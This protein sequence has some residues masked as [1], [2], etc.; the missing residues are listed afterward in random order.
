MALTRTFGPHSMASDIVSESRPAFAAAYAAIVGAGRVAE[1]DEMLTIAA[2]AVLLLHHGVGRLRDQERAEQVEPHDLVVEARRRG[3]RVGARRPAGVVDQYV[4]ATRVSDHPRHQHLD[5]VGVPDVADVVVL[6]IDLGARAGEHPCAGGAERLGDAEPDPACAAGDQH[7]TAGQVQ[8]ERHAATLPS[9]CLVRRERAD[10]LRSAA[11]RDPR[12]ITMEHPP[13]N[14][15]TV[16]GWFDVAAA[17]DEASADH[18]HE[19]RGPP[20]GGQ[21]LQRRRR[22]QGDA[23]HQRVRRPAGRQ[24][25]LLRGVQG[26]LRV[27]GAGDRG[28]ATASASAAASAWS[29]TATSW[30]PATTPTSA[31]PR[32]SR[33]RSARPPTWPGWSPS[34]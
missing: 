30:W 23:A 33:A 15:L 17:L 28:G 10:H 14:A 27:R 16:Q 7:D 22:H 1:T 8:G 3:G 12:L 11:R 5:R 6:G 13:V 21:G 18:G 26:G 2:A 34:T 29:A 9:T 19:G 24:Q 4:E 20:R 32:S 31:S 25:G